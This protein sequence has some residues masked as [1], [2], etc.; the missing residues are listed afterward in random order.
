MA[1]TIVVIALVI[2]SAGAATGIIAVVSTGIRREE[3]N[4][5]LTRQAPD[6]V[7]RGTRLLTGLYVRRRVDASPVRT[8]CPSS[9]LRSK[10]S[11]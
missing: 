7:S 3:Q 9:S 1:A 5:S 10:P 8:D 6:R 11:L 2:F 4:S